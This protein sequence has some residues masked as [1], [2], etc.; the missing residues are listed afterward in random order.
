[1]R[2]SD[3]QVAVKQRCVLVAEENEEEMVVV[4]WWAILMVPMMLGDV[5][6]IDF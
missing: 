2:D 5:L 4:M 3:K 1:M 6:S